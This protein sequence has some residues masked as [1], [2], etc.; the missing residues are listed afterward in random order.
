MFEIHRRNVDEIVIK[1]GENNNL[2]KGQ[3]FFNQ[4][5]K[6]F[7]DVY[8]IVDKVE[9]LNIKEKTV[10]SYLHLFYG[11][12]LETSKPLLEYYQKYFD[13]KIDLN[14]GFIEWEGWN[15]DN[16]YYEYGFGILLSRYFRYQYQL[17]Q[18]IDK[19][20]FSK[21]DFN[22]REIKDIKYNSAKQFRA[23]LTNDEQMLLYYNAITPLGK[24]WIENNY[25]RKYKL[26]KNII[27]PQTI[28]YTPMKWVKEELNMEG[29][30]RDDFFEFKDKVLFD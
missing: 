2:I 9:E 25:I 29:F 22:N 15:Y 21:N 7:R 23:Q 13:N 10:L 8:E 3:E 1:E 24:E 17:I 11:K 19:Y 5:I 12:S 26:I 28:G 20:S 30:E 6:T 18:Y 16:R 14:K 4:I 27:L